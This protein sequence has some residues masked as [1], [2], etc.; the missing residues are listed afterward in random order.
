M[1]KIF[2]LTITC[3]F[4]AFNLFAQELPPKP[5]TLV[6]DYTNTL[7]E[8]EKGSL[9]RKLVMFDDSTSTQVAVVILK[10]VGAYDISQYGAM[11]GESWGIGSKKHNNGVLLLIAINDRKV[12]IQTGYGVEGA[13]PD[14][15]T[16]RIIQNVIKPAFKQGR[17]YQG[18]D[19]ATDAIISAVKGEYNDPRERRGDSNGSVIVF[20]IIIVVVI[21]IV[22]GRRGGGGGGGRVIGSRGAADVLWWTMLSGMGNRGGGGYGGGSGGFGGG[23]GGGF[24]GFGGGSFGGGGSSGSW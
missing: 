19:R 6:N 15:L 3:C 21:I 2:F 14:G 4:L 20:L 24:G 18:I 13:L 22:L 5:Q 1:K 8:E 23:S 16:Y 7:S 12:T 9:E 11:L 10:S 17:Y